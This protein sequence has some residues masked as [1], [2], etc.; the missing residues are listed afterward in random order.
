[1]MKAY[2]CVSMTV[3]R[4]PISYWSCL[5]TIFASTWLAIHPN[6]PGRKITDKGA[7]SCTVERAKIMGIA[8]LAPEVIVAWA[9]EQFKVAWKVCH[10]KNIS[11]AS[12][13]HAWKGGM[14]EAPQG[15]TMTHGFFLGMG[16][17]CYTDISY[18]Q[19]TPDGISTTTA[20][21]LHRPDDTLRP[22]TVTSL[23]ENIVTL[24]VIDYQNKIFMED[25]EAISV[26]T[27]EDKS[28]GDGL[29][30]TISILQISWF[31]AQC[32]ARVIQQ[33]PIT[34]LEMTALAFAG[35]SI[36][37]YCLWWYKPLNVRYHISLDKPDGRKH[38]PAPKT[39]WHPPGRRPLPSKNTVP[40]WRRISV[41]IVTDSLQWF[42]KWAITTVLDMESYFWNDRDTEDGCFR[43]S[44]GRGCSR[45]VGQRHPH[46]TWQ[47]FVITVS[48][49][50]LFGVFHCAAW[51]F[52]FP[53]HTEMILWRFSSVAVVLGLLAGSHLPGAYL[54]TH[55]HALAWMWRHVR[56]MDPQF[57]KR[58][59]WGNSVFAEFIL[60]VISC[61]GIISYIIGR[62]G[63][64]VLAFIQL[65]SLPPLAFHTV[66]WTTH[67]PHI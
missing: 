46:E 21:A 66:Q 23:S 7:I 55:G 35:L 6:V 37:T 41:A 34:L 1:M 25:L 56:P 17:F 59:P 33:L 63:L 20:S 47:R 53:T 11:V 24:H 8:I 28:K 26:Q 22:A 45:V 44:S 42:L 29:S 50:S 54:I 51:S 15:L 31:I 39:I 38:I 32:T 60:T 16:G 43:F 64:V 65:R 36:I 2:P 30:K 3:V 40:F 62:T 48:V 19:H 4:F 10:G 18:T 61:A 57:L 52:Y 14:N 9:V 49:G 58:D 13:I 67:I 5:A 12:V 27:I